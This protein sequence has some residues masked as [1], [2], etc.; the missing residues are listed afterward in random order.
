MLNKRFDQFAFILSLSLALSPVFSCAGDLY[1]W[2]D[3]EGT[4]HMTDTLSQ[5]PAR[6]RDQADRKRLETKSQPF[7]KPEFPDSSIRV[8][9]L[10]RFEIPYRAFEGTSRRIIIPVKFNESIEAHLL[11][12]TG[13]PGLMISPK[14]A[15][16]LGL[17]DEEDATL[18]IM[19]AG[20]GGA[21][22]AILALVDTVRVGDAQSE[23]LPA[24]IAQIP[25]NE[26]EG[27][28]GMDFVSNYKIG[29]DIDKS[30][31]VFEELPPQLD[32]PGGHDEPWWRSSFRRFEKL[33]AEWSDYLD[34]L[35]TGNMTSSERERRSKVARKQYEA[36]DNLCQKLERYA[37]EN[38]VPIQWR[39]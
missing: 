12:D 37:R 8:A 9:D 5:V 1:K 24:T 35:E 31:V 39:H 27:L 26:F 14:L 22:P 23:F 38:A 15:S 21:V 13:S 6:Y 2:V 16:R 29:I 3:E 19:T 30:V 18:K 25:S 20:I 33:R 7:S 10:K 28:V 34:K 32:R 4:V 11:L 36:A 17:L